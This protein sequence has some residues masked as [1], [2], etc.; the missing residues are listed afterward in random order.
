MQ[1]CRWG[2]LRSQDADF[3]VPDNASGRVVLPVT[4]RICLDAGEGYRFANACTVRRINERSRQ[5]S[6]RY[7]FG[8]SL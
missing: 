1:D 3:I 8:R 5:T 2:I 6:E 4:P 7:Y